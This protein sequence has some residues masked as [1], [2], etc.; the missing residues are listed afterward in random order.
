[1]KKTSATL[2]ASFTEA[3]GLFGGKFFF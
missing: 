3:C 1:M 2:G